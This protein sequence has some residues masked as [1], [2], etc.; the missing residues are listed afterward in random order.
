M[1]PTTTHDALTI[2][3]VSMLSVVFLL[4]VAGQA[5]QRWFPVEFLPPFEAWQGSGL[6]Y[7]V[8][9]ACQVAI[10]ALLA[11]VIRGMMR[12]RRVLSATASRCV[13]VIGFVYF[14]GTALRLILGITVFDDNRWF[15]AWIS[16]A[17]HLDLAAIVIIWGW[18]Q[19]RRSATVD[20]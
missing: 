11:S 8:L 6:P 4:R 5:I 18:D 13:M 3:A 12:Q 7:F 2:S 9:L 16:T 10:L 14:A 19:R 17:L 1:R 15:T 20:G